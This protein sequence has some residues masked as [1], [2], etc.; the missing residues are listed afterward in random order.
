[1]EKVIAGS[2]MDLAFPGLGVKYVP[3]EAESRRCWEFGKEFAA[4]VR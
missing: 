2:G 3:D 1:M 4:K